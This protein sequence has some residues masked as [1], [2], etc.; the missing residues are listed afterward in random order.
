MITRRHLLGGATAATVLSMTGM[1]RAQSSKT[2]RIGVLVDLSGQ[3]RDTGGETA[4]ICAKQA[5]KDSGLLERGFNVEVLVADHQQKTDVGVGVVRKWIDQ[6]GV[7]AITEI[8][9]SAIALGAVD[10]IK[11]KDKV[12]LASGPASADFTGKACSPNTVHWALDT[13]CR[14]KSTGGA[15]LKNGGDSWYFVTANY[16]F[17][18]SLQSIATDIIGQNGGKVLGSSVY[19]FPG[20]TDF[21]SFLLSATATNPKVIAFANTA[22]DLINSVKSVKEFGLDKTITIAALAGF[23]TE[24][25]ALGLE[26]AQG[27]ML[28]ETFYWDRNDRTRAFTDRIKSESPKNYPNSEHAATYGS[29]LHYLKTVGKIGAEEAKASGRTVVRAMKA[30]PTDDDCFGSG[31]IRE[32]G[33]A[34]IPTYLLQAK[35][36]KDSKGEWDIFN[37]VAETPAE[38]AF[39]PLDKGLCSMS[40]M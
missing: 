38:Q 14:A 13:Y 18:Q 25:H 22:G 2:I 7:D 28:T 3:Y 17:G 36:P 40:D 39:R 26:T 4:V 31:R 23:I 10:V 27:L 16:A 35:A 37:V 6:D 34:L 24:V 33:R 30:M 5:V 11:S 32:D 1:G 21:S 12:F 19:P 15:I 8:N 9:N 20:T 29:V